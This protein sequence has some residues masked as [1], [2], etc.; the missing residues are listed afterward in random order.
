MNHLE[1]WIDG[2]KIGN[3]PGS[4]MDTSVSLADGTHALTVVEV[5]SAYHYV[6]STPVNFTVGQSTGGSCAPP[7]SPGVDVCS[8][9]AGET[10]SSPVNVIASGTG[11]SGSV[12]HLELWIDGSKIGNYP[13]ASMNASVTLAAGAHAA[14][15]VEVDS[16]LHYVKSNPVNF[17]VGQGGGGGSCAAPS[18]AGAVLCKPVAGSTVSSPVQFTGAG[19]G[20]SGSVNHLE[21]W[22]DGDKIGNYPGST[23]NTQVTLPTGQHTATLVEVDS[24]FHYLKSNPVG[25]TVN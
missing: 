1:L 17:T 12:N 22:I 3:Y 13:G 16:Q 15:V 9:T 2:Q 23:I 6:K 14:T 24:Q 20:A 7:S 21:L 10:V 25:F 4:S 19:T 8:P 5:D 18:S 11:A